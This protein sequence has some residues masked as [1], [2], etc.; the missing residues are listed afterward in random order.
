ML[1]NLKADFEMEKWLNAL[2]KM[3]ESIRVGTDTA[4]LHD[5]MSE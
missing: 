2:L 3:D 4:K 1:S 5:R